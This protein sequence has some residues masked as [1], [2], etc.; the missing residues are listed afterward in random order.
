MND[1]IIFSD[2]ERQKLRLSFFDRLAARA[3]NLDTA[4]GPGE[5]A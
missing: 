2:F 3:I 4:L 1:V 5:P